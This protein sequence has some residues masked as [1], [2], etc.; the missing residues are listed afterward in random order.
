MMPISITHTH[1]LIYPRL[2][3]QRSERTKPVVVLRQPADPRIN[4]LNIVAV[5]QL[6]T[7]HQVPIVRNLREVPVRP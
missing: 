7:L 1:K 4:P 2:R 6:Q 3:E 5:L